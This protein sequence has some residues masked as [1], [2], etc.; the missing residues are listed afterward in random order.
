MTFTRDTLK[1]LWEEIDSMRKLG[2][3]LYSK[4]DI[5]KHDYGYTVTMV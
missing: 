2:Y 1:E 3:C 5:V 4:N